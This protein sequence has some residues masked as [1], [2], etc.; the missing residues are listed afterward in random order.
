V[1]TFKFKRRSEEAIVQA[2]IG[3]GYSAQ[4]NANANASFFGNLRGKSAGGKEPAG[5]P[6]SRGKASIPVFEDKVVLCNGAGAPCLPLVP[7]LTLSSCV[8]VA[9]GRGVISWC[10]SQEN[11]AN[12]SSRLRRP[13]TAAAILQNKS[14]EMNTGKLDASVAQIYKGEAEKEAEKFE[15]DLDGEH[16][17]V[18]EF[19]RSEINFQ[20]LLDTKITTKGQAL[21]DLKKRSE[22]S[23]SL[24]ISLRKAVGE[25][26][27]KRDG[28]INR[29]ISMDADA[30]DKARDSAARIAELEA[31]MQ[32]S[33]ASMDESKSEI[34]KLQ[35][36]YAGLE[37]QLTACDAA[38]AAALAR[39]YELEQELKNE[40]S[41]RESTHAMLT[42]R[43]KELTSSKLSA[44]DAGKKLEQQQ[45]TF[46]REMND[47]RTQLGQEMVSAVF[48]NVC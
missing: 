9:V 18:Q 21:S 31:E 12:A 41:S 39:G 24:I 3:R 8:T 19:K 10:G 6:G 13:R 33:Q 29:A 36:Q 43:E 5:K 1:E 22:E 37:A 46:D 23:K 38:K 30:Q 15:A 28:V 14:T 34:A 48:Q 2:G 35:E 32:R 17:L 27:E 20:E 25:L 16:P 42:I 44:D 40:K 45:M 4:M 26:L 47:L 11:M 7:S